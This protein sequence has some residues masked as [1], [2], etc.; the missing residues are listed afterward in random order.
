MKRLENP[1]VNRFVPFIGI[2]DMP[3]FVRTPERLAGEI[4]IAL[5]YGEGR[6]VLSRLST[7]QDHPELAGAVKEALKK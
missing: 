4:E 6:L 5:K 2:H 7:L 1:E 3:D